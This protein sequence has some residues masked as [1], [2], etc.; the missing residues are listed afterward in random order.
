MIINMDNVNYQQSPV[1]TPPQ[2][3][4]EN[5]VQE[6]KPNK[7][8]TLFLV[9]LIVV[10]LAVTLS[11]V[12]YFIIKPKI[13]STTPINN[14]S[15]LLETSVQL[16]SQP[17]DWPTFVNLQAGYTLKYPRE[18]II[19]EMHPESG[20]IPFVTNDVAFEMRTSTPQIGI[21]TSVIKDADVSSLTDWVKEHSGK[22][23]SEDRYFETVENLRQTSINGSKAVTFIE[24]SKFCFEGP[25]SETLTRWL[26]VNKDN[27]LLGLSCNSCPKAVDSIW[28][29][30]ANSLAIFTSNNPS[31]VISGASKFTHAGISVEY[32]NGWF[33]KIASDQHFILSSF[34]TE[35]FYTGSYLGGIEIYV[36][37]CRSSISECLAS[38][39]IRG[40][41]LSDQSVI[42]FL[43]GIAEKIDTPTMEG[44][45]YGKMDPEAYRNRSSPDFVILTN[46]TNGKPVWLHTALSLYGGSFE[47][48]KRIVEYYY[49]ALKKIV[50]SIEIL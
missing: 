28:N 45:I 25:C 11:T 24:R 10:G 15:T 3:Q 2:P 6:V 37:R 14:K 17:T 12:I 19:R 49:P 34:N 8:K 48:N 35:G 13:L 20:Y 23:S 9:S 30:M 50:Q 1:I 21:V 41:S 32:P 18:L 26:I 42:D 27:S 33:Y 46:K 36:E 43:G 29:E 16:T 22:T 4:I 44:I 47:L 31:M 38:K 7:R 40:S 39:G 5:P